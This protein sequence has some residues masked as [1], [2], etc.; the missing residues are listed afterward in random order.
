[1]TS[2]LLVSILFFILWLV[3]FLFSNET[4]KEQLI[5]SIVGLILSPGILVVAAYDFR[6]IISDQ[7]TSHVGIED[8]LFVFSFF[9]IAAVIYQI[10]VGRH[11]HKLRGSRYE[12]EHIGHWI[13][14]LALILGI[15]AFVT[16]MLIHVFALSSVQSLIV[17]G[18][19]IGIYIIA[20]R[21]DLTMNALLSGIFMAGLIF[22][23][24]QL[25]FVRL[26]PLD[27]STFWQFNALSS[28]VIGGIPMEE[29]MWAAVAG[30]TIGPLYEWLRRYEL[31]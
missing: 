21:H 5:M 13:G 18:L 20:D 15:W 4:R 9:G 17:G 1:M 3:F 28:F 31:K 2:F 11:A 14:H 26:F 7:T 22:I 24:E 25:F 29:L 12:M 30:F 27:A 16:L 8:F 6:N 10:L 23:I 19:F